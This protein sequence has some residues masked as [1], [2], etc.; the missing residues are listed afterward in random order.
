[1]SEWSEKKHHLLWQRR[2]KAQN[3]CISSSEK[4]KMAGVDGQC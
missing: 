1:M 2:I 3:I 4:I